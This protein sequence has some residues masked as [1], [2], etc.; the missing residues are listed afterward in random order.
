MPKHELNMREWWNECGT[1]NVLRVISDLDSSLR[2][3]RQ[4]RYGTKAPSAKMAQRIVDAATKRTPA[5]VPSLNLLIAGVPL[6]GARKNGM[7]APS[8]EFLA[9]A[10][11]VKQSGRARAKA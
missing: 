9:A 3:F 4:L 1:S 2:Y 6:S 7:L 5:C 11:K 10:R 8:P